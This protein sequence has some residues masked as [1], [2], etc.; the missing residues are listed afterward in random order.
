MSIQDLAQSK[1]SVEVS[2]ARCHFLTGDQMKN[3]APAHSFGSE[4]I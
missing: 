1:S 3:K 4:M 2:F